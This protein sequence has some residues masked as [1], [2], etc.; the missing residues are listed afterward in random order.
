[1]SKKK[2]PTGDYAIG[3]AQPPEHSK[4]PKGKSGNPRGRPKKQP[5]DLLDLLDAPVTVKAGD[6][7]RQM[8]P[9][10]ASFLRL[11]QRAVQGNLTAILK[12]IK[13]CEEYGVMAPPPAPTGGGVVVV[14]K[15]VDY[16]AWLDEHTELVPI[17]QDF[18]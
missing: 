14:P 10:E 18:D 2:K 5:V 7:E 11:A 15:N 16:E 1:M 13:I 6:K 4:W 17:D 9:F 12:F 3:Y 8:S